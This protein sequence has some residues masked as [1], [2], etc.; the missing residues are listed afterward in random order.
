MSNNSPLALSS[1]TSSATRT[2]W[3]AV[4]VIY[5]SAAAEALPTPKMFSGWQPTGLLMGVGAGF[6]RLWRQT[7]WPLAGFTTASDAR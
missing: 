3:T 5:L 7:I 1:A 4:P 6:D 2:V